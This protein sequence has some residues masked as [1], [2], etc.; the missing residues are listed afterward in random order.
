MKDAY[1][2]KSADL[3][4]RVINQHKLAGLHI[5]VYTQVLDAEVMEFA[6]GGQTKDDGLPQLEGEF[7]RRKL[8]FTRP[9]G[10][11]IFDIYYARC[12]WRCRRW[13][14]CPQAI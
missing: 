9:A 5:T 8:V 1:E 12:G 4:K 3:V 6:L 13:W 2:P 7:R 10:V 11:L 14:W